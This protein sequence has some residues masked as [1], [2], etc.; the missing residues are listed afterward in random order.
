M[1]KYSE[2]GV[3]GLEQS[4]GLIDEE[5][6][7]QL[8][9]DKGAK[10]YRQMSDNDH[11]IGA[12]LFAIESLL[13]RV[14]WHVEPFDESPEAKDDA[15]FL[16]ECKDDMSCSWSSFISETLTMLPFGWSC[17]ELV[18]KTREGADQ[19]DSTKRSKFNDGRIGWR[20]FAPRA[21]ETLDHW[22]F[23]I[24]GGVKG[25]WQMP[26]NGGASIFLPIEKLMLF[27]TTSRKN[28]PEGRSILRNAYTSWYRKKEIE[29]IESIGIERDLA[30]LPVM[31]VD[32]EIMDSAATEDQKAIFAQYKKILKNVRNDEQMGII[33]PAVYDE[34]GNKM[35]EFSLMSSGSSRSFDTDKIIQRYS[36]N[37]FTTVLADFI[38]LGHEKVGSFALASSKTHI[39]SVVLS[40]FMNEIAEVLNKYAVPRLMRLNGLKP[41]ACPYFRPG[42]IEKPEVVEFSQAIAQIAAAGGFTLGS[43]EDEDWFRNLFSM[44]SRSTSLMAN[45]LP[46]PKKKPL[47]EDYEGEA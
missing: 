44:P 4:S 30:G 13:K 38:S 11:S 43:E 15:K 3:S 2:V 12:I 26:P 7:G 41:D 17:S 1:P 31:Y 28:N 39:F 33:L 8:K 20:K 25:W 40:S 32:P 45:G 34:K 47:H 23:D 16:G 37:I 6:L 21:Q 18:Y 19:T 35:F 27:K 42:D 29:R 22:E 14:E 10:I 5:K 24:D 46:E 9:G 36:N